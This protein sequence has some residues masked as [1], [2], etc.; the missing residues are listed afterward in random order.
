[1][2]KLIRTRLGVAMLLAALALAALSALAFAGTQGSCPSGD[3]SKL[4]LYENSIGDTSDNDDRL[5]LCT[6]DTDLSNNDHTLP[7]N[8]N[9]DGFDSVTWNDCISSVAV[10]VPANQCVDFFRSAGQGGNM[11][12][13]VQGPS[14][15]TRINLP[16]NDQLSG[17]IFY[18]C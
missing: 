1:V 5:W 10:W 8:C 17:F 11:G 2:S 7:G 4:R 15:G 6:S 18:S 9:S 3:T 14:S 13:T 16:Y 12:I